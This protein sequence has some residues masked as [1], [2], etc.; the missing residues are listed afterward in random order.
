MAHTVFLEKKLLTEI[1]L[2]NH[3]TPFHLKILSFGVSK[4]LKKYFTKKFRQR[5]YIYIKTRIYK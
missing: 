4:T 1:N 5:Y 2:K 3:F